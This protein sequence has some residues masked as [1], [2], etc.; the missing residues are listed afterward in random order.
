MNE[1]VSLPWTKKDIWLNLI[2]VLILMGLATYM[3]LV[4]SWILMIIYWLVWV[5]YFTV[6][7]YVTCRHCDF[8]G[9]ACC[10]WC[11]GI[12]G[13]KLYKRSDKKNFAENGMWKVFLFALSFLFTVMLFPIV[14]YFYILFTDSL[15]V[16]DWALLIIYFIMV[17]IMNA[18]HMF[19]GCKK[20]PIV[21]C[22]L[23]RA[24]KSK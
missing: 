22:L 13:G 2:A 4:K 9:K 8:L 12:I 1:T 14:Y 23:N 7:R 10:S 18:I 5:L 15:S 16:V 24:K 19:F 17:L 20:C 6:G 21:E 3:I 11:L